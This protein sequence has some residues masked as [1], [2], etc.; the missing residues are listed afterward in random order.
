MDGRDGALNRR[1]HC[2]QEAVLEERLGD[3]EWSEYNGLLPADAPCGGEGFGEGCATGRY[4]LLIT[5]P[6][7]RMT[8]PVT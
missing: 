2:G 5:P 6:S 8:D 1:H 3:H 7:T 4:T